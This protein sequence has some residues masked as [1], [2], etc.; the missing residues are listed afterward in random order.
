MV[1]SSESICS[2]NDGRQIDANWSMVNLKKNRVASVMQRLV[3][4]VSHMRLA[5]MAVALEVLR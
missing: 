4:N 5:H 1:A 2:D 3:C